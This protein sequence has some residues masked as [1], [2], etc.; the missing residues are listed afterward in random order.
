MPADEIDLRTPGLLGAAPDRTLHVAIT[1]HDEAAFGELY[2]RHSSI[3]YAIALRL[4]RNATTAEEIVQDCFV[5]LW[6]HPDRYDPTRGELRPFLLR[7]V[8]SRSIDRLRSDTRR[9]ARE[10]RHERE[11]AERDA[12]I[13]RE[14]WEVIRGE[15]VRDAMTSLSTGEREALH[16]AYFE[17]LSYREVALVSG[18]AEGTVKGRIRAGLAKLGQQLDQSGLDRLHD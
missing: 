13:E 12:D 14:V 3:A 4:L 16:L 15:I 17:G 1:G 9:R 2:R 8:H 11:R 7:L 18:V 5:S 6:D 10:E